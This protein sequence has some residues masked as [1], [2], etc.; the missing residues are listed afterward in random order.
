MRSTFVTAA[1]VALALSTGAATAGPFLADTDA[2]AGTNVIQVH[3]TCHQGVQ[4]HGGYYPNH[5]HALPGCNMVVVGGG[6]G[7]VSGG[8]V[9][10]H[11]NVQRHYV[12]GYGT[13]YHS[14]ANNCQVQP[15][16]AAPTPT[17]GYGGCISVGG[18][19]TVCP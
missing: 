14:H 16:T 9:D 1:S 19:L 5:Y 10:C 15:Y 12:P 8:G 4:N 2:A 7:G 6:G 11:A 3:N 17:P 13:I 18:V